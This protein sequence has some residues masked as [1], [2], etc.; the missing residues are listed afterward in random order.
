MSQPKPCV[1]SSAQPER[2]IDTGSARKVFETKP[3]KV[4]SDQPATKR[5]KKAMPRAS[6]AP[7]ATGVSG[8]M[9]E[10]VVGAPA[11]PT[12]APALT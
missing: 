2:S 12:P 7:G 8:F 11:A 3:P 9:R 6:R 5:T 4:A 10:L 1:A